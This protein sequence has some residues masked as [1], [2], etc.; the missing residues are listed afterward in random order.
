V[1]TVL[2]ALVVWWCVGKYL[3]LKRAEEEAKAAAKRAKAEAK[4]KKKKK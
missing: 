1:L 2:L 4:A 3:A